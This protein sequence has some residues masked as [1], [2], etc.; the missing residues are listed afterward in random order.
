MSLK[1]AESSSLHL[2]STTTPLSTLSP[3]G[4]SAGKVKLT[5]IIPCYNEKD[6]LRKCVEKVLRIKSDDLALEVIV[7]DDKS[8]DN[9]YNIA[10]ELSS[11]HPEISVLRHEVNQGKG[12]ALRTGFKHATGDLV[13]IQD[14]D[15][16]YDPFDLPR[17][18][19]PILEGS[20]DVV[21]GS[22]FVTGGERRVLYFWHYITNKFLTLASN[23]FTDI[24]L[25]DMETCYKV[26]KRE[27]I[28]KIEIQENRFG[29]EPEI[30]A[31]VAQLGV[32]IY[33]LG[34]SYHG[35]TYEEGKKIGWKDGFRALYCIF[36]YNAFKA[37]APIQFLIYIFIGAVAAVFN[38][39]AFLALLQLNAGVTASAVLAY[40]MASVVNYL[41]CILLLFRHKARWSTFG[42]LIAYSIAVALGCI[43][44][45]L[46]TKLCLDINIAPWLSKSIA[47]ALVLFVNF[48]LRKYLVFPE[49]SREQRA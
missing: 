2:E 20:A 26:F 49:H 32:R 45:L 17:L 33:E 30:T 9:S 48:L 1:Q 15:L 38:L 40:V 19:K 6:T 35:R 22:R 5:I 7:V 36:K 47:S 14:A 39:F 24:N 44:D 11:K 27:I 43:L 16:E 21:F 3:N 41:L 34:I 42:E 31:K 12:A 46:L 4:S 8:T 13:A 23:M 10:M 18:I 37:P 28:E 29:F 25:T